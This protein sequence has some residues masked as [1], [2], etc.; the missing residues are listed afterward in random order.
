MDRAIPFFV[1]LSVLTA[2]SGCFGPGYDPLYGDGFAPYSYSLGRYHPDFIVHHPWEEH[3]AFGHPGNFFRG[4]H[5]GGGVA[6][7]GGGRR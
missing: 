6:G 4:G 3:H 1:A 7:H 5:P 2:L